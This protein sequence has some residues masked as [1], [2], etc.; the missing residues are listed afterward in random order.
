MIQPERQQHFVRGVIA[1][2]HAEQTDFRRFAHQPGGF[3]HELFFGVRVH[4]LARHFF[5]AGAVGFP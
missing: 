3:F 5:G 2:G 4:V 1:V